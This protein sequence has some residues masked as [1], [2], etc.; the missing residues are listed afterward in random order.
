MVATISKCQLNKYAKKAPRSNKVERKSRNK[1]PR[2]SKVERNG[3]QEAKEEKKRRRKV[4]KGVRVWSI[5]ALHVTL[6]RG[7]LRGGVF[8]FFLFHCM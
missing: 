3:R 1:T 5:L 2:S 6:V 7:A 4:A 8:T